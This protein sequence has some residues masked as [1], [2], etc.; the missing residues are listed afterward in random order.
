LAFFLAASRFFEAGVVVVLRDPPNMACP[1]PSSFSAFSSVPLAPV[2]FLVTLLRR[3][4]LVA[5]VTLPRLD[6]PYEKRY[7]FGIWKLDN[8]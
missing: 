2:F 1:E 7:F 4:V 5:L 3:V 8:T 6:V